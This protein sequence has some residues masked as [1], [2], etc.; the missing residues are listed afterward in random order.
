M[1][2]D[3]IQAEAEELIDAMERDKTQLELVT[4]QVCCSSERA[5][6]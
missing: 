6:P 4:S 1:K 3:A 5:D 2:R